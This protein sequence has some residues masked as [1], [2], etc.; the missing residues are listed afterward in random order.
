MRLFVHL[1]NFNIP[2]LDKCK[3]LKILQKYHNN[4][5]P[6][7]FLQLVDVDTTDGLM[8]SLAEFFAFAENECIIRIVMIGN[9]SEKKV[10]LAKGYKLKDY[11]ALLGDL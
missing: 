9:T 11:C 6:I 2:A 3:S 8:R 4:S 10:R 1:R 5:D 7:F